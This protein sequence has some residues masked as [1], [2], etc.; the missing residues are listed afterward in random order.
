MSAS[1]DTLMQ[2]ILVVED[3]QHL[4]FGIRYNLEAEG[5]HVTTVADGVSAL[6]FVEQGGTPVD[7][8][9][10]DIMLPGMSGYAVCERIRAAGNDVPILILSARTLTEDRIRG[11][12][13]GADQYLQKPFDLDELL[14][15][16]R[17]LLQRRGPGTRKL[18]PL[19]DGL[20]RFGEAEV[21]FGTFEVRVRGEPRHLTA[22]QM[23]LLR[24]FVD[25]EN[26]VVSRNELLEHVWGMAHQPTTRTVD[27]FIVELRKVFEEDPANPRHILS[28]RGAGY[29]FVSTPE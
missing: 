24:Y 12:D 26:R 6:E 28:V 7:L 5:Y 16:V 20:Y 13:V 17:N 23:K 10:L 19:S 25:H 8:I 11:Y 1:G 2:H 27:N 15:M 4:A 14:S 21:N 18:S 22:L 3:E 29:R 9:I